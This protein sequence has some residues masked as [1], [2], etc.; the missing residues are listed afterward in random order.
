MLSSLRALA[1]AAL[2]SSRLFAEDTPAEKPFH[3][4]IRHTKAEC[5]ARAKEEACGSSEHWEFAVAGNAVDEEK[6]RKVLKEEAGKGKDASERAVEI[7]GPPD[8]PWGR[9]QAAMTSCAECRIYRIQWLPA[10]AGGKAEPVPAW[11]PKSKAIGEDPVP[12]P[13][14]EEV[15]VFMRKDAKGGIL[16]KVNAQ[17][18]EK[19]E[20][21]GEVLAERIEKFKSLNRP[22]TPVVIDAAA[23]VPWSA[24][25]RVSEICREK[26]LEH[27]E[28]AAPMPATK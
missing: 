13:I 2:L 19:D 18:V 11:L 17:V 22:E 12:N 27:V 16:R 8:A 28:F 21:L 6:L 4:D 24:V 3:L 20:E 23:D 10:P 5:A 25:I 1:F 14:L 9:V 26:K 15:R 7:G